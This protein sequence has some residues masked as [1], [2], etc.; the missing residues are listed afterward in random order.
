MKRIAII[1]QQAKHSVNIFAFRPEQ[2][3]TPAKDF[4]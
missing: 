3:S 2:P 1:S 4:K